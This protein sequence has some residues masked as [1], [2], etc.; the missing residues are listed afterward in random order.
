MEFCVVMEFLL[1]FRIF[2]SIFWYLVCP[3][4]Q[5]RDVI[6]NLVVI[7]LEQGLQCNCSLFHFYLLVVHNSSKNYTL[8]HPIEA[9]GVFKH[10]CCLDEK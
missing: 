3:I 10:P 4:L 6:R 2:C 8:L 7:D 5:S 1:C 9:G